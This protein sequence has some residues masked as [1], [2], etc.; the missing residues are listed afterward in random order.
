MKLTRMT[1]TYHLKVPRERRADVE[2]VLIFFERGCPIAQTLKGCIEMEHR[3]MI[4][5]E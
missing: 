4:E 3:S 5:E 2:R 1:L